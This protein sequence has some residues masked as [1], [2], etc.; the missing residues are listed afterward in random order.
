MDNLAKGS[1]HGM[2]SHPGPIPRPFLD[3]KE[4]NGHSGPRL[5]SEVI[6]FQMS[7]G[8]SQV[9]SGREIPAFHLQ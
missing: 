8:K 3:F 2:V 7:S 1:R 6:Y 4:G 5:Q 9:G